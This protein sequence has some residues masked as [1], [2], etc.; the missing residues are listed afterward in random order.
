MGAVK[1]LPI[2]MQKGLGYPLRAVRA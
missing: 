1:H 2:A